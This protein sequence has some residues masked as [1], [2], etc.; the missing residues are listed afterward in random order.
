MTTR[1]MLSVYAVAMP[2]TALVTPGPGSDESHTHLSGGT[3]I[4]V[5]RVH[6]RLLMAHQHVLH[7]VLL[8]QRVVNVEDRA[9]GIAPDVFDTFGLQGAHHD[10]GAHELFGSW[11]LAGRCGRRSHFGLVEISMINLSRI[12][13]TK[14]LGCPFTQL[15][16]SG[17]RT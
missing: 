9:T 8:V 17:V 16:W 2:V 14:Y 11:G 10:F 5:G 12:S 1:G 6:R 3:R 13:L 7:G 15:L 4:A